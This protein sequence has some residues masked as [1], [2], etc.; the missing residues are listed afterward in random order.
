M[1]LFQ[2]RRQAF[3]QFTVLFM[4]VLLLPLPIWS[5]DSTTH[6][7]DSNEKVHHMLNRITYGPTPEEVAY[8]EKI[9]VDRYL[10]EQLNPKQIPYSAELN[11]S[12]KQLNS[13]NMSPQQLY[14]T[15]GPKALKQLAKQQS[16]GD[17]DAAK[18]I[19]K[20]LRKQAMA[21]MG[22]AIEARIMRALY[23]PRQLEEKL[24]EFWFNHFN[25]YQQKGATY[26]WIGHYENHAIRP[27]VL[28]RFKDMLTATAHH[29]AMQFYL[30][31]WLNTAP[32]SPGVRGKQTGLNE[33][34]AR[35]LLEL[36]TLGVDGGYT[37]KDVTELARVLTGWGI[38][39]REALRAQYQAQFQ[40]RGLGQRP[41]PV[42]S[43][44]L[45]SS[46]L[47]FEASRHDFGSKIILGHRIQG[48]GASELDQVLDILAKHPATA[49]HLSYQLAQWFV[50]DKPPTSLVDRMSQTYLNT[51]GNL[52]AVTSAMFHSPEFWESQY[53]R[54]KFK[55]PYDYVL[56]ILR[57]SNTDL[58]QIE[59]QS[60]MLAGQL[61]KMGM[62]LYG[63]ETPN[64]YKNT[65]EAWLSPDSL[66]NRINLSTGFSSGRT[67][68]GEPGIRDIQA[69][70]TTVGK[71]SD[72]T[73]QVLNKTP[74]A[75]QLSI[76]M[77][78]PEFMMY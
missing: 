3:L 16:E 24:S 13:L 19:Q 32:N 74:A 72:K 9:G 73:Q 2:K 52:S 59:T 66:T 31:N 27:Y 42:F 65:K 17:P 18:T 75:L 61:K 7:L 11:Q 49:H 23:S 40:H 46:G 56:S 4:L 5:Q 51:D 21:V 67:P 20:E 50:S 64:G 54:Q 6:T 12:L 35:E 36:H 10:N 30:D 58:P 33:N 57:S 45:V 78:S 47:N 48:S 26:V 76:L 68:L 53:Y 14:Q 15:Y 77:G 63:C 70:T 71:L 29:P 44:G 38:M 8:V 25:V 62:P 60:L 43:S 28:G 22:E 55:T 34:Y 1:P 41:Q 37:Q 39:N 69:L